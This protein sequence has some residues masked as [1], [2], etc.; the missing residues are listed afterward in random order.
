MSINKLYTPFYQIYRIMLQHG[1]VAQSCFHLSKKWKN[2]LSK[3][4]ASNI[5]HKAGNRMSASIRKMKGL[6]AKN[7]CIQHI[8]H[9]VGTQNFSI[10]Q[11]WKDW[12]PKTAASNIPHKAAQRISALYRFLY[13]LI[14][15]PS[16]ESPSGIND[17]A[18]L[19]LT[20]ELFWEIVDCC[21]LAR[22][23]RKIRDVPF[24][25]DFD[26]SLLTAC[27]YWVQH[28]DG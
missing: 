3:I 27:V 11:K 6:T 15:G 24:F 22:N 23:H 28:R 14:S 5:P 13:F 2:W 18:M 20:R 26:V 4:T 9:K 12:R 16:T 10:L 19:T 21:G 25:W 17:G 8:L 7:N 1:P